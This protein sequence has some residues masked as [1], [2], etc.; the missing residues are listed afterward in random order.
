MR[1]LVLRNFMEILMINCVKIASNLV[2]HV[3]VPM[4]MEQVVSLVCLN[5]VIIMMETLL[6]LLVL[7][8]VILVMWLDRFVICHLILMVMVVLFIIRTMELVYACVMTG[9]MI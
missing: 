9:T 3:Q 8:I 1:D 2:I 5:P 6:V 4:L 7:L